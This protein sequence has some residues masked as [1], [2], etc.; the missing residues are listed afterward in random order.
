MRDPALTKL[1][2]AGEGLVFVSDVDAPFE[3]FA[4]EG[5]GDP[6]PAAVRRRGGHP[7]R[8][9][10]AEVGFDQFFDAL[11]RDQDWYGEEEMAQAR[12]YQA[13]RD[14]IRDQLTD[15]KVYRVGETEVTYYV[16]GTSRAGHWVGVKAR[17]TET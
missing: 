11:T 1:R 10:V 2:K 13:L 12:K 4:W 7:G 14:T 16:V 3:A 5:D 15:P 8:A 9:P 6:G 17:A